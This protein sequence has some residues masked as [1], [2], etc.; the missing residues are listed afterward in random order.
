MDDS[1]AQ[2]NLSTL[3]GI[4]KGTIPYAEKLTNQEKLDLIFNRELILQEKID[5]ALKGIDELIKHYER[6]KNA[7]KEGLADMLIE[8]LEEIKKIL[9]EWHERQGKNLSNQ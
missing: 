8:E 4:I 3:L 2:K 1:D 6:L 5:I 9:E 7:M